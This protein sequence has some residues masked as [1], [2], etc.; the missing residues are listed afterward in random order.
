MLQLVRN[1]EGGA[2]L[3]DDVD[4][5]DL[6]V[7]QLEWLGGQLHLS[8]P[9]L[10][11]FLVEEVLATPADRNTLAGMVVRAG[12]LIAAMQALESLV[13]GVLRMSPGREES[14][15]LPEPDLLD[16]FLAGIP[17]GRGLGGASH[18]LKLPPVEEIPVAPV[19]SHWGPLVT[20]K[21]G[22]GRVLAVVD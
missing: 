6:S 17:E 9:H 1:P 18:R 3:V 12:G 14:A 4:G 21:R 5:M 20:R 13:L 8:Y 2:R 7:A 11:V 19:D 22:I 15:R 10:Y 16:V